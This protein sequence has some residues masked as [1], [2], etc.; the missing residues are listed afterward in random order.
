M[1]MNRKIQCQNFPCENVFHDSYRI[2]N[3][4]IDPDK[5][6]V[7]VI[8]ESAAL[9]S[10]DDFYAEQQG[11]EAP[12]FAQTTLMAFKNGGVEASSIYELVDQG[13]YFTTAIKCGK[14]DY[15]IKAGPITACSFLLEQELAQFPNLQAIML[16]GDAAIKAL[17]AIAKRNGHPRVIPAVSTYKLRGQSFHY[18]GMRVLPSYLQAG[19]S[20][21]IE[22]SKQRMIAEDI[23]AVLD[24]L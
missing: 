21:F 2:P 5:I 7:A 15:T 1:N 13:F 16:M 14:T 22:K 24:L 11:E 12:L 3:I 10:K 6:K 23:T 17:N 9:D 8:S 18:E 19:P 20:F 4:E